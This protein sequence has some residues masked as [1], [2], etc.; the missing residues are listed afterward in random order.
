[1]LIAMAAKR[2]RACTIPSRDRGSRARF[3]Q[4][5]SQIVPRWSVGTI[6]AWSGPS[7]MG[8]KFSPVF[9]PDHWQHAANGSGGGFQPPVQV[10]KGYLQFRRLEAGATSREIYTGQKCRF[11]TAQIKIGLPAAPALDQ[12][13]TEPKNCMPI[14]DYQGFWFDPK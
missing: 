2:R 5:T 6:W 8:Q 4:I 10:A 9:N 11:W 7:K 12:M 1:M 14:A 3:R 13:S